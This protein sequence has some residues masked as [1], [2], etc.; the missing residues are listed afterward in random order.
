[1]RVEISTLRR[2]VCALVVALMLFAGLGEAAFAQRHRH[3]DN[4][5]GRH[6]GWERG[7]HRGWERNNNHRRFRRRAFRR[8]RRDDR[9][10]FRR[11]RRDD[12]RYFARRNR[13]RGDRVGYLGPPARAYNRRYVRRTWRNRN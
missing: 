11:D 5:N 6:L 1:M 4:N 8:E 2:M 12:R 9:R 3:R 7:R 13:A 10:A